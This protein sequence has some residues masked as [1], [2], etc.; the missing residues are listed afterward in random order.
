MLYS[1]ERQS[2][3]PEERLVVYGLNHTHM[4]R[5]IK[6]LFDLQGPQ[7]TTGL[8]LLFAKLVVI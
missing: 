1:Q 4:N 5:Q 8:L 6:V 2:G 3:S 7:T